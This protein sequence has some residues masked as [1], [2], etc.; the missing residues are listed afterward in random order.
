MFDVLSAMLNYYQE[1]VEEAS[2]SVLQMAVRF[3]EDL[4]PWSRATIPAYLIRPCRSS[5]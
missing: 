1:G 5:P 3:V 2:S 4:S